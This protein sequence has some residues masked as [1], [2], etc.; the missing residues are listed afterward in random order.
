MTDLFADENFSLR[1]VRALRGLGHDVRTTPEA[2]LANQ[3]IDDPDILDAATAEGRAVLTDNR[4]DF[5]RL[6]MQRPDHGGIVVCTYDPDP[7][8]LAQRIH[9]AIA[10]LDSLD[11]LLIRVNR[12]GPGEAEA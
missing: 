7:E 11:G 1:M 2:G 5:I 6:H 3:G 9:T 12:P 4:R 10:D 8:R